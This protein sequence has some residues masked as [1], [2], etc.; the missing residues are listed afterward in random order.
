MGEL[1]TRLRRTPQGLLGM[2][3]VGAMLVVAIAGPWLAP[4]DPE[5]FQPLLRYRF[6]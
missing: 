5:T 4:V 1:F 2:I 3:L 6:E